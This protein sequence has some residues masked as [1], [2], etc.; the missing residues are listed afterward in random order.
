M[1]NFILFMTFF[2]LASQI[3]PGVCDDHVFP[4]K[5]DAS[6]HQEVKTGPLQKQIEGL[7][8]NSTLTLPE[9]T[10]EGPIHIKVP[11]V[12]IQGEDGAVI[13][14]NGMG[15][16]IVVEAQDVTIKG[17][18]LK[19]SGLS[20]SQADSGIGLRSADNA[21]I[22]GNTIEDCL[23]GIDVYSGNNIT[24]E[25]NVISSKNVDIGL[26][27]DAIRLWNVTDSHVIGN[28]WSHSRDVVAWYSKKIII[29]DNEG[30]DSRYS[31]H[32]MYSQGIKIQNNRFTKNQVGIF[33]MYG[34]DFVISGNTIER[35]QGATGMGIGLKESS[36]I[37]A[38]NN[39][40]NYSA[41]GVL[42]DN[43]PFNR[44]SKNWF[45][46][47][48]IAF[49]GKGV[50]LSNDLPGGEFKK[51]V[52]IGNLEDVDTDHRTGSKSV[53]SGNFWDKYVGFDQD[54]NNKGDQPFIVRKFGDT[55]KGSNPKTALFYGTPLFSL[56][57]LIEEVTNMGE[58]I[59]V[60]VDKD[61][62][63]LKG[64]Q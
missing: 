22:S 53:W 48:R 27:G 2:I 5:P 44:G 37:I 11:G 14:G 61:P 42:I 20:Y 10:H 12:T 46:G 59:I 18:T 17:L 38:Q 58:P 8:P 30:S 9:G 64:K 33:L 35:S 6:W 34:S 60:L 57:T 45:H 21:R 4:K 26:R 50:L 23:F 36:N 31:V 43:S 55:L 13:D 62:Y 1:Q 25:N 16:V 24:L 41:V 40:I 52:F 51:N 63:I 56:V 7:S 28:S 15:S 32:S 19:G 47:N 39:T 49:N 3:P 54:E 29:K